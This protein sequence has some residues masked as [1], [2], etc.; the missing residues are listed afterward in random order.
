MGIRPSTHYDSTRRL[1]QDL[2][3]VRRR[4]AQT[5]G[6]LVRLARRL[7]GERDLP[8]PHHR[9]DLAAAAAAA[10]SAVVGLELALADVEARAHELARAADELT[11]RPLPGTA[12][13]PR[14]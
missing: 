7:P 3:R 11:L 5:A 1:G 13:E 4:M 2:E 8:D 10:P 9:H 12:I 6:E 14:P